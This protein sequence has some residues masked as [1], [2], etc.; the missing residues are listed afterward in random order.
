MLAEFIIGQKIVEDGEM[1]IVIKILLVKR[2]DLN[3]EWTLLLCREGIDCG[4]C[5]KLPGCAHGTC[6]DPLTNKS[7]PFTCNCE[8]YWGGASCDIRK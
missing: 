4:T 3:W 6:F 7:E 8:E 5:I 2:M 1:E